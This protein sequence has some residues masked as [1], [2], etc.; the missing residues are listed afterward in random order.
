MG[1]G[2]LDPLRATLARNM[3]RLRAE[4]GLT[5]RG[6]AERIGVRPR[7]ITELETGKANPTLDTLNTIARALGVDPRELTRE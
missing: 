5:Q 2:A 4:A 7:R 3:V 6:L 1:R